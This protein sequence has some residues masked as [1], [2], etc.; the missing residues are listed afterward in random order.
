[1]SETEKAHMVSRVLRKYKHRWGLRTDLSKS[2][3]SVFDY[4]DES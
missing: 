2:R 4:V 3:V 1:M